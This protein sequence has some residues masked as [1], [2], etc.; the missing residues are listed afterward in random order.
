MH[1]NYRNYVH[2][3]GKKRSMISKFLY[4]IKLKWYCCSY[5]LTVSIRMNT[6]LLD[7][8][9]MRSKNKL[10]LSGGMYS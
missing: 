3:Y 8:E 1:T 5:G 2:L 10:V 7:R 9:Q 6:R 4:M